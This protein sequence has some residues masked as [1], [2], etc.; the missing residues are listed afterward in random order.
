M[1]DERRN[2]GPATDAGAAMER[3]CRRET[4][5]DGRNPRRQATGEPAS[6]ERPQEKQETQR[7]ERDA[8]RRADDRQ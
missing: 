6:E 2:G 1:P 4:T 7:G 5:V 8:D 3:H